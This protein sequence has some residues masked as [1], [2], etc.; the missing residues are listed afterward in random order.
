MFSHA[1]RSV[2]IKVMTAN[3]WIDLAQ[4]KINNFNFLFLTES[5]YLNYK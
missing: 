5:Y 1:D 3:L 2:R 4:G